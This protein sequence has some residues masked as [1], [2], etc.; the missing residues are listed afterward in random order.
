MSTAF[1]L[2]PQHRSKRG[3]SSR[4]PPKTQVDDLAPNPNWSAGRVDGLS[5]ETALTLIGAHSR[6]APSASVPCITESNVYYAYA[7]TSED[8]QRVAQTAPENLRQDLL[9]Q[10]R[11]P[12][13]VGSRV[14]LHY[15]MQLCDGACYMTEAAVDPTTG[16]FRMNHLKIY[17][18]G[19]QGG[20]PTRHIGDFEV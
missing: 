4:E 14:R 12:L 1:G 20:A 8:L 3:R 10:P 17:T 18:E 2:C 5:P 6:P 13:P 19:V 15:P 7:T 9:E 16:Q 11:T